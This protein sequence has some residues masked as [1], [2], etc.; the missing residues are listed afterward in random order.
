[1]DQ[2]LPEADSEADGGTT[3]P[4][5]QP[6]TITESV[7]QT[8]KALYQRA[9]DH[10]D[11]ELGPDLERAWRAYDGKVDAQPSYY[12]GYGEDGQKVYH[13]SRAVV[14]ECFDKI[15]AMLPELAR[16]FLSS[17]ELVSFVPE[18]PEDEQFVQQATD[19]AN[20]VVGR[21]NNGE[22]LT[23]DS[24]IDWLVKFC[25]LKVY[26]L[27]E[28]RQEE[29][30]FAGLEE[31]ALQMLLQLAQDPSSP[32][33]SIEAEPE[34]DVVMMQVATP[35]GQVATVPQQMVTYRGKL[36]K[37]IKKGRIAIDLLPQDEFIIDPDAQTEA[38]SLFIGSDGYRTV[39]D[40]VALGIPYE[41]VQEHS[42]GTMRWG[43]ST[44]VAQAR[45]GRT[46]GMV[47]ASDVPDPA[48]QYVRFVEA[49]VRLDR[50]GD[51]IAERYRTIM[52]GEMPEVISLEPGDDCY[53]VVASPL[54]RPHEPIGDGQVETL[55]D[56][57]DQMT[58]LLRG[59]L[60]SL[61]R[62]NTPR[63][64]V[65]DNDETAYNDLLSPFGGPVRAKN[66][67]SIAIHAIPFVGDRNVPLI[68]FLDQRSASRTG[69]SMAGQGLDPD[70]LKGQTVDAAK[71]VVTAP[72][73]RL[74]F[75][76]REYAAGVMR[77]LFRAILRLS[78]SHQDKATTIRLRNQ[79]VAV[80]PSQ[81]SADMDCAVKV[82]LGA[83][84][85]ME[86][87][88]G[89]QAIMA[90]QEA[91]MA[92]GSPLV[93]QQTY[94]NALAQFCEIMGYKNTVR[95]FK[96]PT[97]EEQQAAAQQAEQ[98]KQQAAQQAIQLEAAKAGAVAQEK[99]KGD[100][101]IAQIEDARA[102]SDAQIKADVEMHRQIGELTIQRD[103]IVAEER[104]AMARLSMEREMKERE[105]SM[106]YELEQLK[107]RNRSP[108]GNGDIP[109][110]VR[111]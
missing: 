72:Q 67:A 74:E 44:S 35:D 86:R 22:E 109:E 100:V 64:V 7:R 25:A 111:N 58:A 71:A 87:L 105:L 14:R 80:D 18:G 13:G 61:N 79:W 34:Q 43:A 30:S 40:V 83:G 4:I 17:D 39:S 21:Q 54:R 9:R 95:F 97:P 52:L 92:M 98:Q 59:W 16:I 49:I 6:D 101:A 108:G 38:D 78:K 106:Q 77:P 57:Q 46:S 19:Y 3:A 32:V 110:V 75:L 28:E 94:G 15:Q 70:V 103:K 5:D 31:H 2:L 99:A 62:S 107:M 96:E 91:L 45:R 50:D 73:T 63:E 65:A 42:G 93:D 1:M 41:K 88:A 60:N 82:G 68:Q 10:A 33:E 26:W 11:N 90:K 12:V 69:V 51:G 27:V 55:I 84:T 20:Y 23:L 29:N 89:L 36:R 48:L 37:N 47:T 24:F 76:A 102:R 53:Y 56:I 66:P 104:V 85:K 81:W 8:I